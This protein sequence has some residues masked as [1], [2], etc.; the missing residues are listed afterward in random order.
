MN[1][2]YCGKW[3]AFLAQ[4]LL[5]Q[6][7]Q[8]LNGSSAMLHLC[9]GLCCSCHTG[10]IC[11]CGNGHADTQAVEQDLP[12]RATPLHV[13]QAHSAGHGVVCQSYGP[14]HL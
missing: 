12:A 6:Q 10:D 2:V 5:H 13:S 11:T 4:M 7:L 3:V 1:I 9:S 14:L 8:D